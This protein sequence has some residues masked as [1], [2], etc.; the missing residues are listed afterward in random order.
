MSAAKIEPYI[1][2]PN[3]RKFL[4][5]IA[6]AE[7]ANYDTLFGGGRFND[8]SQHPN[9]R[10]EFTQTDGRRN[11]SSAAGRYQFLKPTW[12]GLQRQLGLSDFSPRNQDIAATALLKQAGALDDV[13]K[14]NFEAAVNKTGRIWAS[15][16]SSPYA[17]PKKT[18][19]QLGLKQNYGSGSGGGGGAGTMTQNS[20]QNTL[21]RINAAR[22]AGH[23]DAEIFQAM[24]QAPRYQQNFAAARQA[25]FSDAKIAQDLGLKIGGAPSTAAPK[26]A[27]QMTVAQRK[28]MVDKRDA[29]MKVAQRK[30]AA[31][32]DGKVSAAE[33]ALMGFSDLGAGIMQGVSYAADSIATGANKL[34]G[35][36][37]DNK[38]YDRITKDRAIAEQNY[39]DRR[40][41]N[42][43]DGVDVARVA[44]DIV[45]KAPLFALT[46]GYG[47]TGV[48]TKAGAK[49]TARNAVGGAAT[50]AAGFAENAEKRKDNATVGALAGAVAPVVV[51]GAGKVVGKVYNTAKGN[52]GA[53]ANELQKT[54][55]AHGIN[56]TA[57]DLSRSAVLPRLDTALESLPVIGLGGMREAQQKQVKSAAMKVAEKFK[58]ALGD[59]NF[60]DVARIQR[61]ADAGDRQAADVLETIRA[62]GTDPSRIIQASG[63]IKV[64]RQSKAVGMLYD[65]VEKLAEGKIVPPSKTAEWLSNKRTMLEQSMSP[66]PVLVKQV[67][68]ITEKIASPKVPKTF[69]NL[70]MLR[71]DLGALAKDLA[72]KGDGAAAVEIGNLKAAVTSDLNTFAQAQGGGIGKAW[73]RADSYYRQVQLAKDKQLAKELSSGT[74]DEIIDKFIKSSKG[75]RAG[76]FLNQLD[77]KGQ[78]AVRV[79]MVDDAINKA[80][81]ESSGMFSP[82]KFASYFDSMEAPYAQVFKGAQKQE[83]DGFV[84]LMRHAERAAQY[85]ENPPTGNRLTPYIVGGGAA[86][87]YSFE[88]TA[89]LTTAATSQMYKALTTTAMGKK[90][91]LSAAELPVDSPKLANLFKMADK[92][93]AGTLAIAASQD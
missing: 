63:K 65:E 14:G 54:A 41:F 5:I 11:V 64:W 71:S 72:A 10:K 73:K 66:N 85:A 86:T 6:K 68:D 46:R 77:A 17:Q 90:L 37:Y 92:Y 87:A 47:S 21:A 81:T 24:Q 58:T 62:A 45:G 27:P 2:N 38:S 15:L 82:A 69:S 67:Q 79:A 25:G 56:I 43:Q 30:A 93:A 76:R 28:A 9:M 19:A 16:P 49:V 60:K 40:K 8:L 12:D 3:V 70:R 39:R 31:K 42:N 13:L 53:K 78:A 74:P 22:Q 44:G 88:P 52:M 18:M 91:L 26:Q 84:K 55:D 57:G 51:K 59:Q 34:L 1:Y 75:D 80:A 50:G 61:A 48:L 89:L 36:N 20:G 7:G 35:T 33:S 23:S 4:G 29:D 32:A 83:L